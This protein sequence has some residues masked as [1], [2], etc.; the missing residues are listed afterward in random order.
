MF[1]LPVVREVLQP[2]E[3][4]PAPRAGR[5][6]AYAG[7]ERRRSESGMARRLLSAFDEID[8]GIV[9]INEQS[10]IAYANHAARIDLDADHP[11]RLLHSQ[12]HARAARDAVALRDALRE[13]RQRDLRKLLSV[14]EA[15]NRISVAVVPLGEACADGGAS[16]TLVM[17][18]R[19][20]LCEQLSVQGF[21]RGNCLT[22]AET[23]V[24]VALC[25][26]QAPNEAAANL[27]VAISTVR[28]QI[29]NIRMKT[30][31]QSIGELLR[32]VAVLPPLVN[33]LRRWSPDW[34]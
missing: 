1:E 26:G 10:R 9:L 3:T 5:P 7:P 23:R 16:S 34:R 19:R 11:L 4:S 29:Y 14:G 28:T 13:A 12:L 33:S 2:G 32:R 30:G 6:A 18:G 20:N 21:A 17:F 8:Y 22:A 31:A 27:G 25:E 24:L 15:E